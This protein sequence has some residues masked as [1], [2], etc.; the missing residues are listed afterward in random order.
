MKI[1]VGTKNNKIAFIS[2]KAMKVKGGGT[3]TI[4]EV[5]LEK[6]NIKI[7]EEINIDDNLYKSG[8][9][10]KILEEIKRSRQVQL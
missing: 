4:D 1:V 7:S 3:F 8:N 6:D 10:D 9:I 5:Q 2:P